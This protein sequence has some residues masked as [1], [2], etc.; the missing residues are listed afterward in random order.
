MSLEEGVVLL[1]LVSSKH[2]K[3]EYKW[4]KKRRWMD[5]WNLMKVPSYTCLMYVDTAAQYR[6]T[7]ENK[8]IEFN[9]KG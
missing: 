5:D 6:C 4:E 1:L 9:V 3:V 8:T 2:G 7:V